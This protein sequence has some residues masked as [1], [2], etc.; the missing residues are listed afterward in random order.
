MTR[1]AQTAQQLL[2]ILQL[3]PDA[4][5]AIDSD[6]K[7][8]I[9]NEEAARIFGDSLKD[10]PLDQILPGV[11]LAARQ[12]TAGDKLERPVRL[13]NG[14]AT[15]FTIKRAEGERFEADL[16][17]VSVTPTDTG[18]LRLLLISDVTDRVRATK[19]AHTSERLESMGL[20]AGGIAHDFNNLLGV[21]INYSEFAHEGA[22]GL[23]QVQ[24]DI[25]HI[26][27]AADSA[28]DLTGRLL[29]FTRQEADRPTVLD[30]HAEL[31]SMMSLVERVVSEAVAVEL[32]LTAAHSKVEMNLSH[33][34]QIVM[35]LSAN[36]RDAMSGGGKLMILTSN[37][38]IGPG[39]PLWSNDELPSGEYLILEVLDDGDG[40]DEHTRT[41]AIEP[42]FTTKPKTV[43]TGLGLATVFAA[44]QQAGGSFSIYSEPGSGTSIKIFLPTTDQMVEATEGIDVSTDGNG[45]RILVAEDQPDLRAMV[46]RSLESAGYLVNS[47]PTADEALEHARRHNQDV[48]LVLTDMVMPGM[49]AAEFIEQCK[50]V[51]PG[52][53]IVMMSG[54]YEYTP[55]S[56]LKTLPFLRKP[57][58]RAQL[59]TEIQAAL[60]AE[61]SA[62]S[63]EESE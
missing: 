28:A 57:F 60:G 46:E 49:Q 26:R 7:V 54:Y 25:S 35:N 55:G 9:F 24:E 61:A 31:E 23:P 30:V 5:L 16:S 3:L 34:H 37:V 21:I 18:R 48:D 39:D 59:L 17:L 63:P 10:L 56:E 47:F 43:G 29:E 50:T 1:V 53:P 22:E 40:M 51:L 62:S 4:A 42:F 12:R 15:H 8:V 11:N 33:L 58:T 20:M 36:A 6:D 38:E 14:L 45:E 13:R 2:E 19:K 27:A 52:I 41:H 32:N 44:V